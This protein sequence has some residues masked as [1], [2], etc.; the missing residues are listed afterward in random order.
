VATMPCDF[1]NC[2]ATTDTQQ[3]HVAVVGRTDLD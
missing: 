2:T 3:C 1:G